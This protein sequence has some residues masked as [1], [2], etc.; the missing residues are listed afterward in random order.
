MEERRFNLGLELISSVG[1]SG[2]IE[3]AEGIAKMALDSALEDGI[4]KDIPV[5]GWLLKFRSAYKGISERILLKKIA[6][7]LEGVSRASPEERANFAKKIKTDKKYQKKVGENLILLIER[8]ERFEKSF[9]L[10]RLFASFI[11]GAL[12]QELFIR[13]SAALDKAAIEDLEA[14]RGAESEDYTLHE[15]LEG[16]NRCGLTDLRLSVRP[17]NRQAMQMG[18]QRGIEMERQVEV[19][20]QINELGNLFIERAMELDSDLSSST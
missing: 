15:R 10:G 8:H 5:F 17:L 11:R 20:Y 9:L 18:K 6:S 12:S 2:L 3:I 13:L 7:F 1:E 19:R 14:L 16:L 4:V